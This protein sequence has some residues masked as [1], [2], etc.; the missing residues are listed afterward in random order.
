MIFLRIAVQLLTIAVHKEM[1][2]ETLILCFKQQMSVLTQQ[3]LSVLFI[4][5]IATLEADPAYCIRRIVTI[6]STSVI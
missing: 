3:Q 6:K 4:W 1:I 5:L 2:S